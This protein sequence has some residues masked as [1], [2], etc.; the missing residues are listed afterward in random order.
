MCRNAVNV[1]EKNCMWDIF[2]VYTEIS[3]DEVSSETARRQHKSM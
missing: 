3:P 1:S 2:N